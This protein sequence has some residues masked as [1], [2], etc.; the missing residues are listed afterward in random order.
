MGATHPQAKWP[1]QFGLFG[2]WTAP[3]TA[4]GS[5]VPHAA[6]TIGILDVAQLTLSAT[7]SHR[8]R[9]SCGNWCGRLLAWP[10]AFDL[11]AVALRLMNR[12][13]PA[14]SWAFAFTGSRQK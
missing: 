14:H 2:V 9:G 10:R 8:E 4:E 7:P 6:Q 11:A 5:Y 1:V 3:A 13:G 12:E